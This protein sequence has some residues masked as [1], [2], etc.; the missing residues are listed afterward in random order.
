MILSCENKREFGKAENF[1]ICGLSLKNDGVIDG[2]IDKVRDHC[3]F[4]GKY[5]GAAPPHLQFAIQE[6]KV[7][8]IEYHNLANYDSIASFHQKSRKER[9]PLIAFR[10]MRIY[11]S[12]P[13]KKMKWDLTRWSRQESRLRLTKKHFQEK[14][15]VLM[16]T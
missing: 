2:V 6:A 7:H 5:R 15:H 13:V 12:T 3:H 16:R 4:T 8:S 10:I 9:G 11:T 1:W 14:N